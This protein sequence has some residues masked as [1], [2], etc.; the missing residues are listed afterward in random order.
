MFGDQCVRFVS[1]P[2]YLAR[3]DFDW[4]WDVLMAPRERDLCVLFLSGVLEA[5]GEGDVGE[6]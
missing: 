4:L 3:L 6:V 1:F 5:E 2:C